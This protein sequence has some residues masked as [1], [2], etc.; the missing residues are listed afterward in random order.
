[1]NIQLIDSTIPAIETYIDALNENTKY[2]IYDNL[3]DTYSDLESRIANIEEI[4]FVN[5]C[6]VFVDKHKDNQLFIQTP[7]ISVVNDVIQNND[8]TEF[9]LKIIRQYN[10]Q[11]I[12]FLGCN[13]L[14]YPRWKQYFDYLTTYGVSVRASNDT[15]GNLLSGGNWILESTKEDIEN[16]YY[17]N[18]IKLWNYHLG[19]GFHT[20]LVMKDG[21]VKT[22]GYCLH[23]QL[24]NGTNTNSNIPVDVLNIS[25]AISTTCG[26]LHT[27]ILL[28]D[29]TVKTF[30]YNFYGQLGNGS[31]TNSNIPVNVLN[32]SNAIDISCSDHTA[33]LLSDGTVKTFGYNFYG[34][35][36]NG[37]NTNSNIP[38][39]VLNI[40]NAISVVCGG[41]HTVVLLSDGTVKTFGY[42]FH[43]QL[44]NASNTNSGIPVNVSGITNAIAIAGGFNHT[45]VL[46][47][48]GTIKSFGSN[49]V[50]QLGNGTNTSSNIP[51][52]VTGITDAIAV[53]CG[54]EH[55]VILLSDGTIKSFGSNLFG[56]LGNG[57]NTSSDI[58]VNV[59][60]ITN[61]IAISCGYYH[62]IVLLSDGTVK[63]FGFN[64]YGQLGNG[65]TTNRNLPVSVIN[66]PLSNPVKNILGYP[67]MSKNYITDFIPNIEFANN[68]FV[69]GYFNN[70][71]TDL[72]SLLQYGLNPIIITCGPSQS[73]FSPPI[74]ISAMVNKIPSKYYWR[75][76]ST[77][78]WQIIT[79]T[80]TNEK[81]LTPVQIGNLYKI[82]IET[83]HF[84][85]FAFVFDNINNTRNRKV[86][87]K[88][89]YLDIRISKRICQKCCE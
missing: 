72:S 81:Y 87:C 86:Y 65:T 76:N 18:K 8:A 85:D 39:N 67:L 55:T 27:T 50:G 7:F 16:L 19:L 3:D 13:L 5:L 80:G 1:M 68:K 64:G 21:T 22:F 41:D 30:G 63:T 66:L 59:F 60:G 33:V 37:S 32:I 69:T 82:Q 25:N 52:N 12:D 75:A 11:N 24:G 44:G 34:Q 38:V 42:N 89:D 53:A 46:L 14:S 9:I 62:T 58:P 47:S 77:S 23:G 49:L 45:I 56:Q 29:G 61:A 78:S 26:F 35:L 73:T 43:G 10:I 20:T 40:T 15:T 79:S 6:F 4:Q 54:G 71:P 84:T 74:I 57:T 31:N 28:S 36:G 2:V 51:V 83:N 88:R 70:N 17:T 48:D